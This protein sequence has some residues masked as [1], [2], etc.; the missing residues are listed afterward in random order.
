MVG[1]SLLGLLLLTEAD[2]GFRA[3]LS[4]VAGTVCAAVG[5]DVYTDF[6][7]GGDGASF[8]L[9]PLTVTFAGLGTLGWLFVR[10]LRVRDA[11]SPLDVG[12]HAVRT[13]LV[14]TAFFL[15]L[16]LLSRYNGDD[17]PGALLDGS[18]RV[19]V[20]VAS[21]LL[22]AL[23]F[24]VATL[25]T[26]WWLHRRAGLHPRLTWLRSVFLAPLLGALAVFAAGVLAVPVYALTGEDD[27]V[28]RLGKTVLGAGNWAIGGVLLAAGVPLR[29]EGGAADDVRGICA[30]T[31][32][33]I[34]LLSCTDESAWFWLAPLL[35][36]LVLLAVAV[37]LVLRQNSIEDARREGFRFAGALALLAFLAAF[38]LRTAAD[39]GIGEDGESTAMFNPVLAAFALAVWG[40]VAGLVAPVLAARASPGLVSGIRRRLGVAGGRPAAAPHGSAP[41]PGHEPQQPGYGQAGYAQQPGPPGSAPGP[42]VGSPG[43]PVPGPPPPDEPE[44]KVLPPH[45][46][47][48]PNP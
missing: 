24:A 16:S 27:A 6:G 26:A 22:G 2:A 35:L 47:G 45:Q 18:G 28:Q 9:L 44:T 19:G 34:D 23:L 7:D 25:G 11:S 41:A 31:G 21:T 1:V 17:D 30:A 39:A 43:P 4:L 37:A 20:S 46:P 13:A 38:L 29:A 3:M 42:A 10:R 32:D 40:A 12:L 15:V 36:L 14:F 33:S 48:P 8:G 5:G